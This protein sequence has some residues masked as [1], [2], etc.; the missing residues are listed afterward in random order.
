[1]FSDEN[2]KKARYHLDRFLRAGES[3]HRR[4]FAK[5]TAFRISNAPKESHWQEDNFDSIEAKSYSGFSTF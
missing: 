5:L 4:K 1:M 2:G 3:N